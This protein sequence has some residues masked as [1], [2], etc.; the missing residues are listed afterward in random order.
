MRFH[1]YNN[2]RSFDVVARC[3]SVSAGAAALNLTKGAVSHQIRSLEAALGIVLFVRRP[4]GLELTEPGAALLQAARPAFQA[5]DQAIDRLARL[6]NT[7]IAVGL[8]TYVASRWLMPRLMTFVQAHPDARIQLMP[9]IDPTDLSGEPLDMVIRWGDGRWTD[10]AVA[11]LFLCPA[12]PAGSIALAGRV[13]REGLAAVMAD[14]VLLDD[15]D[16]STAWAAWGAAAGVTLPS[17]RSPLVIPDPN[18]RV[19]AVIAGQG[20][21]LCDDLVAP[22]LA[23]GQIAA[24]SDCRLETYGYFLVAADWGALTPVQQAF[25]HWLADMGQ[26]AGASFRWQ[27]GPPGATAPD[28][29]ATGGQALR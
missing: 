9:L 27:G 29:P 26:S 3:G 22:E 4:R 6:A 13:R 25:R 1:Q 10:G 24:L 23:G 18:V 11:P 16:G 19:Q 2:L 7:R 28:P 5:I 20:M 15:R 21:A 14:T 12:F 8:S 17:R